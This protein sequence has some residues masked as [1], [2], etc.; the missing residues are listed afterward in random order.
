[1]PENTSLQIMNV[2]D[3]SGEDDVPSPYPLVPDVQLTTASY[4]TVPDI[5]MTTDFQSPAP[6]ISMPTDFHS[7]VP[8]ISMTTDTDFSVG[9]VTSSPVAFPESVTTKVEVR[10]EC[11]TGE[12]LGTTMVPPLS[13]SP[14]AVETFTEDVIAVAT[15]QPGL[16]F[17]VPR[18][19]E[20]VGE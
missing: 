14:T 13:F 10:G 9:T 6:E 2:S 7:K 18:H 1:M 12:P 19:N 3:F 11:V 17:E 20:S 15:A 4:Y 8:D 16:G 5:Y